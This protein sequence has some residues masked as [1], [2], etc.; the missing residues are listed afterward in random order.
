VALA[1]HA[2]ALPFGNDRSGARW[3]DAT[4]DEDNFR[5]LLDRLSARLGAQH[6]QRWEA[7]ADHRPEKAAMALPASEAPARAI[8][9][10]TPPRPTWL[11]P[12]PLPLAEHAG[13]PLHGGPLQLHGGP[14]RIEA[15]WFDG[16]PVCRDYHIASGTDH[17]LRWVFRELRGTQS[18]WFLHGLFG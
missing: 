13:R 16:A 10:P 15:G 9:L 18:G 14:E 3:H 12:T 11:L 2:A 5:A 7:C 8:V 1:G 4:L 17:R 6:V